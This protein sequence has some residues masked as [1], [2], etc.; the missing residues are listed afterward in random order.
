[1]SA[2]SDTQDQSVWDRKYQFYKDQGIEVSL[3]LANGIRLNGKILEFDDSAVVLTSE[4]HAA[5]GVTTS[6]RQ[7]ATLMR[8]PPKDQHE[9]EHR[10][11]RNQ[12]TSRR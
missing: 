6:R 1:M 4:H 7:V 12:N 11:D 9:G 5:E 8:R 2:G 3:F 10:R